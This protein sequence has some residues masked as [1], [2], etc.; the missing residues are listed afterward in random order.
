MLC[1]PHGFH[2]SKFKAQLILSLKDVSKAWLLWRDKPIR[3]DRHNI[4]F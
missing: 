4:A 2:K 3:S 1:K